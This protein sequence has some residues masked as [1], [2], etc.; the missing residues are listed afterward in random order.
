LLSP[1]QRWQH[2][3]DE[4]SSFQTLCVTY[5]ANK[6]DRDDSDFRDVLASYDVIDKACPFWGIGKG[7][8]IAENELC[9]AIREGFPAT[10]MQR[11]S[12]PS[13][14]WPITSTSISPN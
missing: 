14:M 9:Y 5:N 13:G 8:I 4:L 6:R 2:G 10:S 1:R 12:S 11:W 3:S 7:R